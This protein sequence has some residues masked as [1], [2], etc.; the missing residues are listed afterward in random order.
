MAWGELQKAV[1]L[2][3]I[4]EGLWKDGKFGV[5]VGVMQDAQVFLTTEVFSCDRMCSLTIECVLLRWKGF[6]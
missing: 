1:A 4:A 2:G 5:A 6:S 3:Y